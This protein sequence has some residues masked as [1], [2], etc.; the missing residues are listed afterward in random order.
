MVDSDA[1]RNGLA[2]MEQSGINPA[3]VAIP[4]KLWASLEQ[5]QTIFKTMKTKQRLFL[6]VGLIFLIS[7]NQKSHEKTDLDSN[8]DTVFIEKGLESYENTNHDNAESLIGYKKYQSDYDYYMDIYNN[9]KLIAA[10]DILMLS[11]PDSL[12]TKNKDTESFY[13]IVFTK[14]MNGSDGFYS[15]AVGHS[16]FEYITKYPIKFAAFFLSEPK[17]DREDLKNWANY[18]YG[19]IQISRENEEQQVIRE[20]EELLKDKIKDSDKDYKNLI[21][22]LIEEIK[23]AHNRAD[24]R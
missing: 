17:L 12:F 19:E 13:F 16:C 23:T 18:I 6:A 2:L 20:L 10:D 9:E 22:K 7:C 21:Y 11:I 3:T 4:G 1:A 5:T 8:S 24:G 15:E 14:S